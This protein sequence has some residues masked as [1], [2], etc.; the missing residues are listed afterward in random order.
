MT[1]NPNIK[2]LFVLILALFLNQG[3]LLA[4]DYEEEYDDEYEYSGNEY[5]NEQYKRYSEQE[6]K[7]RND[8]FYKKSYREEDLYNG[9]YRS[10]S[11]NETPTPT[12]TSGSWGIWGSDKK[13]NNMFGEPQQPNT[14]DKPKF[15]PNNPVSPIGI[16]SGNETKDAGKAV[17]GTGS[18]DDKPGDDDPGEKVP[19]PPDEPDVP[20][21]TAIPLLITGAVLLVS[22]RFI[23]IKKASV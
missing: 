21:D 7:R 6:Y 16:G 1:L 19:P 4:Q 15:N 5:N 12:G 14:P 20:V 13:S 23:S 10:R 11:E 17:W 9:R 3:T 8:K 18:G 22:Y 2:F